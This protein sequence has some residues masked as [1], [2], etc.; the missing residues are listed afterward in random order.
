MVCGIPRPRWMTH[1]Q[2]GR[3]SFASRAPL[4][5]RPRAYGYEA[6]R[7]LPTGAPVVAKNI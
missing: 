5:T 1:R 7:G 2:C 6:P 3:I 4:L